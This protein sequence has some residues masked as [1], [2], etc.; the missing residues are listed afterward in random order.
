MRSGWR[1]SSLIYIIILVAAVAL[2]SQC[3]MGSEEPT[4]I[5][6]SRAIDMSQQN[7][8]EKIV[9][10]EDHLLITTRDG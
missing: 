5:P 2:V 1:L 9:I 6:L 7:E 4:E 3:L 10:E 8:I